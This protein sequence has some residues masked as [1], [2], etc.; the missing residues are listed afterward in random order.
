MVYHF[1]STYVF[2]P[3]LLFKNKMLFY[4]ILKTEGDIFIELRDFHRAIQA[5]KSLKNYCKVWELLE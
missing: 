2:A 1:V 5:Y 3:A 4:C